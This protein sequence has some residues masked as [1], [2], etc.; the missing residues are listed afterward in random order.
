MTFSHDGLR[1]HLTHLAAPPYFYESLRRE[2]L[3]AER[4][5]S[6]LS[7]VRFLLTPPRAEKQLSAES[8][9]E[10]AILGFA[11]IIKASTRGEDLCARLG[12][13]EFTLILKAEE[14]VA[15]ELAERVVQLWR[16]ES[17]RCHYS[18][19]LV[20]SAESSLEILNRLDN[21]PLTTR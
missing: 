14:K 19:L 3:S 17:F 13:S 6:R 11:E 7:L 15:E 10:L 12:K 2:I 5:K 4:N 16:S 8:E 18:V 1:D 21:Q 20:N 9:Y